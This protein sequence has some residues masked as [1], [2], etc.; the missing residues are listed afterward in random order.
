MPKTWQSFWPTV[1]ELADADAKQ[2]PTYD[3]NRKFFDPSKYQAIYV[4]CSGS[5]IGAKHTALVE[6]LLDVHP[7]NLY[8]FSDQVFEITLKDTRVP[9]GPTFWKPV[10]AHLLAKSFTG[11]VAVITDEPEV[12]GIDSNL[13]AWIRKTAFYLDVKDVMQEAPEPVVTP[14]PTT[15][16]LRESVDKLIEALLPL[17]GA[18]KNQPVIDAAKAVVGAFKKDAVGWFALPGWQQAMTDLEQALKG[19]S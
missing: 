19:Q 12:T 7:T 6:E 4:D 14:V 8:G 16:P 13:R 11:R 9:G 10:V 18:A 3:I 1:G 17:V 5:M 2:Q 15:D